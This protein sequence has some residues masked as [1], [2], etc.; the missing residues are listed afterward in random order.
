MLKKNI[1]IRIKYL[2]SAVFI[3]PFSF[4]SESSFFSLLF[5]PPS[6][7][8]GRSLRRTARNVCV[9]AR[10]RETCS[11]RKDIIYL[12]GA[13]A[14]FLPARPRRA[15]WA[16][17]DFNH[18]SFLEFGED[19]LA[20]SLAFFACG[21]MYIFL[22]RGDFLFWPFFSG[23]LSTW[24]CFC[25]CNAE[26]G[27]WITQ[28]VCLGV[29]SQHSAEKLERL[30]AEWKCYMDLQCLSLNWFMS[31]R[32]LKIKGDTKAFLDTSP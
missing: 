19:P 13:E 25:L 1:K 2:V 30:L 23:V 12:S 22:F 18:E 21:Y 8:Q 17:A 15:R 11:C 31:C 32:E 16:E 4:F 9:S 3:L 28:L 14:G 10:N 5:L 20:G 24:N 7:F 27:F 26:S 29:T 6:P